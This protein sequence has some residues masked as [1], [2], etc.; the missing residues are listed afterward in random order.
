MA[1]SAR[2]LSTNLLQQPITQAHTFA[3][4]DIVTF[5][6]ASYVLA[7]ADIATNCETPMMV[8]FVSDANHFWL[9]QV[10][11]V[12]QITAT[13]AAP[14]FVPGTQYYLSEITAGQLTTIAPSAIGNVVIPCFVPDTATS[15]YFFG[16]L[17]SGTP[18]VP[19]ALMPWN[20]VNANTPMVINNGYWVD[21]VDPA[22]VTMTLP[23]SMGTSDIIEVANINTGAFIIQ[24]NGGQQINFIDQTTAAGGTVTLDAT[25][26]VISGSIIIRCYVADTL[27]KITG[28]TGNF[29]VLQD[30]DMTQN[31][32][33]IRLPVPINQGGTNAVTEVDALTNLGA[34]PIAGGTMTGALILN[35]D[36]VVALGAVTK[37][38]ADAIASGFSIKEPCVASTTANLNATYANGAAGVGATLTNAGANAAF[39]TDG[40]AG[41]LND[42]ILVQFQTA[43][44][45]NGI[46]T[47]TTVGDGVTP[48]V[49]TRAT[50]FDETTEIIPGAFVIVQQGTL[51]AVT[52]WIQTETVATIGTDPIEFTQFTAGV[53]A[54]TALSN[55]AS[56]AIN[57]SLIS[58][59]D[60]TDDLGSQSKRWNNIYAATLQTGD[61]AA[62]TLKIGAYDVD[63]AAL[64][65]F[66]T[67]T[68][69]NTPTCALAGGVTSVTQSASDNSTKIATTAYTDNQATLAASTKAN[70]SLNNLAAVAI[71][72]TLVSDTDIT[73]DLGTQ[74]VRWRNIYTST[75]QTGDTATDTLKIG[76]WDVDGGALETFITLTAN[77]TPTCV[78]ASG[79]TGTTQ[80]PLDNSTKLATTAYV[81]AATGGGS[82]ANTA[83]SNLAAVAINTTLVSDTDITDD[84][85]TQVIRW[86]NIYTQTVQTG[87]TN[88]DTL[89]FSGWNGA[90]AT[91]FI[92]ITANASPTCVIAS[93]VTG[94][95]QAAND[96]STK[97]ATTAYADAAAG[98][99]ANVALSNLSGVAINASLLPGTDNNISLGDATHR[100]TDMYS[101]TARTGT[102]N[103]NSFII[104]GRNTGAGTWADFLTVTA[105]ATATCA[106][107]GSV[108]GV[109]QSA[110][111]NSTKLATTAY[112]D[113]QATLAASGKANTSLNNLASVAINTSLISDTDITDNLG[114][115][116]IRW[117]N[118]YTATLQTGDTA[119]DTLKIGAWDVDGA[120]LETFI[121]LTA[122]NTPTCALASGVTAV[123]QSAS[124]N[125]T[126]IATT[127][128]VDTAIS[129][130]GGSLINLASATVS[131][132]AAVSFTSNIDTTYNKY[133]LAI[134][135]MQPTTNS[136][137][138]IL[139]VSTDG[140]STWK[141]G[142][143]DYGYGFGNPPGGG[144]VS[145]AAT[146]M[147]IS[148]GSYPQV[149]TASIAASGNIIM[150]NPGTT[151]WYTSFSGV[152]MIPLAGSKDSFYHAGAYNATTAV[153]GVRIRYSSGNVTAKIILYGFLGT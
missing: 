52:S 73:D 29:I 136:V 26:G 14:P 34:L 13:P 33:G 149:N 118:I 12:S 23:V 75:V 120:A 143:S 103:T 125:S 105:A 4:G 69:D 142:A 129:A 135:Y 77:N 108:T 18:V 110:S 126:K 64:E 27:F 106:L 153:N 140:G 39:S 78:F 55:L 119:A 6:G 2:S 28:S 95:T 109:T 89:T 60:I 112:A 31:S 145:N 88:G 15:G 49:L 152:L 115:Q 122:N 121:T 54:N 90:S 67:L 56:V 40:I 86:R 113:N 8:S 87:D 71:N 5:N 17:G 138:P 7:Q 1:Y 99:R 116:A 127:A 57:T 133:M 53:G 45:E 11:Y 124:D 19:P 47:I 139:E 62:D 101:L 74:A 41:N 85:G 30:I 32:S 72:T 104:Q 44:E 76:A 79:V 24:A 114:S 111:D 147:L 68:A 83:L 132:S 130:S 123:T 92:T 151:S 63:G 51:Y 98:A 146:G 65:T 50:D 58:D 128:Y 91:P 9:T 70:T 59:T 42:R 43:T 81:D 102:T 82:G 37:Q 148:N 117:N 144:A 35:A 94:T 96:N 22:T 10:G 66:I 46:Y 93:G 84:L 61:T 100:Y 141:T 3:V 150:D 131:G 25:L 20:T 107:A 36:P 137:Y 80:A 97:L 21:V 134:I 38:Y 16:G 48:W